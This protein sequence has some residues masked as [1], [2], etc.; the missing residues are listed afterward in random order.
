MTAVPVRVES[1]DSAFEPSL[2]D[3]G[4]SLHDDFVSNRPFPHIVIDDVLPP[5]LLDTVLSEYPTPWS[6]R[7]DEFDKK[8]EVEL[9][10]RDTT[11]M[12]PVTRNL[13]AEF[14]GS[15]FV[16]FLEQLTGIGGLIPDPH[17]VG[18]GLHQIRPGGY[19]KV[20]ADF[21]RHPRL[22]LDR[23]LNALL[24]LNRDWDESYGG[25]LELWD[26]EMNRAEQIILP[27]FNRMVIFATTDF[28]YHGHP[29]PL[30]CPPD[31]TRRSIALYYYTNGRP[32]EEVTANH[33]T[34]FQQRPGETFRARG[35]RASVKR[36]LPP[37]VTDAIAQ[38]RR[39]R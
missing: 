35:W 13:L 25:A 8:T 7:W 39:G 21:N 31:R 15:V 23:R 6:A 10:L 2:I 1:M 30:T 12:G 27:V 29:S 37:A 38:H 17:Y 33:T 36:W 20:H 4:R 3:L 9:A 26:E 32:A 16:E 28:S 19:L 18:G 22:Q 11:Q 14:N 34:L 5:S 24:Y